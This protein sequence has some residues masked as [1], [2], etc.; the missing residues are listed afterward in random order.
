MPPCVDV[1]CPSIV[2]IVEKPEGA[3]QRDPVPELSGSKGFEAGL[4]MIGHLP[5]AFRLHGIST[6]T[7]VGKR[8]GARLRLGVVAQPFLSRIRPEGPGESCRYVRACG[9]E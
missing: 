1:V 6:L 5:G 2:E 7:E 4:G 9:S 8:G 3:S